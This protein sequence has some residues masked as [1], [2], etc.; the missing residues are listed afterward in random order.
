MPHDTSSPVAERPAPTRRAATRRTRPSTP[1]PRTGHDD[2]RSLEAGLDRLQTDA[3][4]APSAWSRFTRA[5]CR[6]SSSCSC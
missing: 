3:D 6:P 5:C 2:L 4:R 1:R